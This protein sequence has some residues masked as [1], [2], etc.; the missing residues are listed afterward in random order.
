MSETTKREFFVEADIAEAER[1]LTGQPDGKDISLRIW[2]QHAHVPA[3]RE[4]VTLVDGQGTRIDGEVQRVD[5][6]S[7]RWSA[8]YI[9]PDF[10]TVRA[11]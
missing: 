10:D 8:V 5:R 2:A 6:G 9:C 4:R 7:G 11:P 3:E 1:A